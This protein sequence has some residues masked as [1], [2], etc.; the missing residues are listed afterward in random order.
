M[1]L[2]LLVEF[3]LRSLL[4]GWGLG[5][6][7]LCCWS[8]GLHLPDCYD[9]CGKWLARAEFYIRAWVI[10]GVFLAARVLAFVFLMVGIFGWNFKMF[11]V[12]FI[13][14]GFMGKV[15]L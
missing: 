3:S 6:C 4:R 7:L 15:L 11:G 14:A 5:L 1:G 10:G 8:S 13:G 12:V 9:F 2:G